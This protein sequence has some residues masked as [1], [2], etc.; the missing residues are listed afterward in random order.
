MRQVKPP[1]NLRA[2][3]THNGIIEIKHFLPVSQTPFLIELE[4]VLILLTTVIFHNQIRPFYKI[5]NLSIDF[6]QRVCY[7]KTH[8]A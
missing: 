3:L 4:G 2:G 7:N 8:V 6:K 1:K 5:H